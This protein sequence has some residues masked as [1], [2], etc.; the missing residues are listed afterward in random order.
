MEIVHS[1]RGMTGFALSMVSSKVP[2]PKSGIECANPVAPDPSS[3]PLARLIGRLERPQ[4][5]TTDRADGGVSGC[6]E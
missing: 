1:R 2:E 6:A 5:R 3:H 4:I